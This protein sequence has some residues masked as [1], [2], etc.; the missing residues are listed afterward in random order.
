[1]TYNVTIMNLAGSVV[2]FGQT[3]ARNPA[4]AVTTIAQH[5]RLIDLSTAVRIQR[6]AQQWPT[7]M[8]ELG[9]AALV[10]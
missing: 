10:S 5:E 2:G 9:F 3:S 6:N 7:L 8:G 1:M 4:H